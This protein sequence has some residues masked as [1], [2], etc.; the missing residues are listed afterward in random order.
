LACET[1]PPPK[2]RRATQPRARNKS[3]SSGGSSSAPSATG[4]IDTRLAGA[5]VIKAD[6]NALIF[7][8]FSS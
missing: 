3:S 7:R 4:C 1:E 8:F 2:A 5:G 6:Y